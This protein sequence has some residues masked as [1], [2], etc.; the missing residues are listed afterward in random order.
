[1]PYLWISGNGSHEALRHGGVSRAI[2][3]NATPCKTPKPATKPY[4]LTSYENKKKPSRESGA[5]FCL[6]S[7]K[8]QPR[9]N[10]N[11]RE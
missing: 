2:Y 11:G 6:H 9:M 10:A 8:I 3:P 1:M 7:L 4:K 5:A